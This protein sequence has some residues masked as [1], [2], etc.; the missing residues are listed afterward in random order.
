M[1]DQCAALEQLLSAH[2]VERP[3]GTP[4]LANARVRALLPLVTGWT[5]LDDGKSIQLK[6]RCEGFS[7]A[8]QTLA[9]IATLADAEDHHPDARIYSYRW[10]ELTLS[11]HSI[12]GL[13]ENDFILAAKINRLLGG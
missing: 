2:C 3:Q 4:A 13:S 9:R 11:T 5:L 1:A 10:L 8:A 12:G 6:R 7:D